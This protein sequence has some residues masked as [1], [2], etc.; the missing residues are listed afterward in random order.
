MALSTSTGLSKAW[1]AELRNMLIIA[2]SKGVLTGSETTTTAQTT[3]A[4]ESDKQ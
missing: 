2:I 1:L 3:L 4:T